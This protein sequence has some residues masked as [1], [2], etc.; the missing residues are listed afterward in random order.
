M[1]SEPALRS[2]FGCCLAWIHQVAQLLG[3]LE[4]GHFLGRDFHALA[5]LGIAA[6]ARIALTN[7]ERTESANLDL[8]AALQCANHGGEH[9]FDNY[10]PVVASK[11][12]Q[13]GYLLHQVCLCHNSKTS[14]PSIKGF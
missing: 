3:R 2:G 1:R 14:A 12:A 8:V 9:G 6:D 10:F 13:C 11:V 5:G 4:V 7:A